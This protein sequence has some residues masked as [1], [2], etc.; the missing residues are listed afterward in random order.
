MRFKQSFSRD[1]SVLGNHLDELLFPKTLTPFHLNDE[2]S[3]SSH[4]QQ[5]APVAYLLEKTPH[6]PL[7]N[8]TCL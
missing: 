8:Q 5:L 3:D 1:A 4:N 2:P 7:A 6:I